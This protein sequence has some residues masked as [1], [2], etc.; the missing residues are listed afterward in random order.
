[1]LSVLQHV[2]PTALAAIQ[3][4]MSVRK[5]TEVFLLFSLGSQFDQ[6]IK[7]MLDKIGVYCLLADPATV[8]AA[9]VRAINPKGIILSGGPANVSDEAPPFDC[10]I[11]DLG[12]PVLG[13]CLGF[14]L[15]AHHVGMR[16]VAATHH[17]FGTHEMQ[18]HFIG[19]GLFEGIETAITSVLESHRDFIDPDS[20]PEDVAILA[21][22]EHAPIAAA[23]RDTLWGVQYHPEV[24]ETVAGERMFE[25]FCFGICEAKDRFPA[26]A[27]VEGKVAELREQI[28]GKNVLIATSGGC[29]SSVAAKL[30]ER[31]IEGTST[32]VR[33]IYIRGTDRPE[34]EV[35]LRR[36]FGDQSWIDI[37]AVDATE[38]L[39][40]ALEGKCGPAKRDAFSAAYKGILEREIATFREECEGGE[41][42]IVQGTLYTDERESGLGNATGAKVARIKRHHNVGLQFSA[43]ELKPLADCVKSGV[44]AMGRILGL[45][46]EVLVRHPFPGPGL[47]VRIMG[48]VTA[49]RLAM[50]RAADG[51]FI[52]ELRAADLYRTVWQAGA[53]VTETDA[54]CSKGDDAATGVVIALWAKC[55][56][57]GFTATA[58][59]LPFTF[60]RRVSR[61]ITNEVAGVGRVTY[62]YT[63]KPPG[64][65]EWE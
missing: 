64:T 1:M 32:R 43:T 21:S 16:V 61:C 14:Q 55:S 63:D 30:V 65:I 6:L 47:A 50:A 42:V 7:L 49:L 33:G 52:R 4:E 24:P 10:S 38:E 41:I 53:V 27:A 2:T 58:A 23:R 39:L 44:R 31:A 11:F 22:T 29:D 56:V 13:I 12:I 9:D 59:E 60:L 28:A 35:F 46:E 25:N 45:P 36:Y 15:W 19:S 51:I 37:R 62:D 17:E 40:A 8:T 20:V 54:T 3:E 26:A 5:T 18:I 48:E 34:D 57:D